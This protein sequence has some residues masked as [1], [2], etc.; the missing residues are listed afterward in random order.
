[1]AL[2][3]LF[4]PQNYQYVKIPY[5]TLESLEGGKLPD[6][7]KNS[8][9]SFLVQFK[10]PVGIT[11]YAQH[12]RDIPSLSPWFF[13]MNIATSYI[14]LF[15][16]EEDFNE[17]DFGFVEKIVAREASGKLGTRFNSFTDGSE[18]GPIRWIEIDN[19][20]LTNEEIADLVKLYGK[21]FTEVTPR[22]AEFR[23]V[24]K[25]QLEEL[26]LL[27]ENSPIITQRGDW[28]DPLS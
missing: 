8:I 10:S 9:D 6:I 3:S 18:Y 5:F 13:L 27:S 17:N 28:K 7:R 25:H 14:N 20:V 4:Q 26:G 15:C 1:M 24:T 16:R 22:K 21:F 12:T 11:Y 23:N 2:S 19:H